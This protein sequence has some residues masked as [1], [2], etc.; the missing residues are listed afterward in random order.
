MEGSKRGGRERE[1][2]RMG[3][4]E[5]REGKRDETERERI[6]YLIKINYE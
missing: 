6:I 3:T 1:S 4:T 5:G 2:E